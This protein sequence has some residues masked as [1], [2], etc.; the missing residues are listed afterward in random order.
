MWTLIE[1]QNYLNYINHYRHEMLPFQKQLILHETQKYYFLPRL[2]YK[3]HPHKDLIF[4]QDNEFKVQHINTKF[5]GTL[6]P[7]QYNITDVLIKSLSDN[8]NGGILKSRPASGKTFMSIYTACKLKLKTLII[9]DQTNIVDQWV[10]DTIYKFTDCKEVGLIQGK[11]F[12]TDCPFTV[13]MVQTLASK[14]KLDAASFNN[15]YIQFREAGFGLVIMDECHTVSAGEKYAKSSIFANTPKML[16]LSASPY[17]DNLQAMYMFDTI[18]PVI[19]EYKEYDLTP[20]V[21]F[22]YYSSNLKSHYGP[23]GK[24]KNYEGWVRNA[25]DLIQQRARYNSILSQNA[26]FSEQIV[27]LNK[28]LHKDGHIVI[29]VLSTEKLVKNINEKLNQNNLPSKPFYGKDRELEKDNQQIITSTYKFVSKAFDWKDLSALIIGLPLS[30]KKSWIQLPGR[31]LRSKEGK[32]NP[33]IYYLIDK[34]FRYLFGDTHMLT[35][36]IKKEYGEDVRINHVDF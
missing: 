13:A 31:I 8:N 2:F 25:G 14:T 3:N 23:D 18:G 7:H 4:H 29:N 17:A 21:N 28:T 15:Y 5:T 6:R 16:G 20:T 22:V 12:K 35:A 26:N 32:K 1:K 27:D 33:V 30:G 10:N 19:H 34:D 11:H 36:I 24:K 9:L